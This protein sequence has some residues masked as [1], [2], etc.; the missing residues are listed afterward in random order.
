MMSVSIHS[1]RFWL[2]WM[3][4]LRMSRLLLWQQPIGQTSL[5]QLSLGREDLTDGS[6][7]ICRIWKDGKQFF[8]SMQKASQWK[9]LL[10]GKKLPRGQ[11][12]LAA[13]I[14]K[15]C[16]MRQQ[17]ALRGLERLR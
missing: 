10:T 2:K 15:T 17:L 1:I 16:L 5:I 6:V 12:D 11:L 14:W 8:L 4:F 7:W 3:D 13:Q 9:S